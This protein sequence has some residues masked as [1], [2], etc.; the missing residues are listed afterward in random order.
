M[1]DRTVGRS[2]GSRPDSGSTGPAGSELTSLRFAALARRLNEV[3]RRLGVPC[4][5][6]RSPPKR[7]GCRRTIRWERDGS[8][9]VSVA[10]RGRPAVAVA[11]DMI[12]GVVAAGRLRGVDAASTRD[13]LWS[14]LAQLLDGEAVGDGVGAS[15]PAGR[16]AA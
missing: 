5:G 9:T 3:S 10:L 7:P 14:A 2:T 8:A 6:F 16:S 11:N 4:P 13:E 12:D 15:R 1:S